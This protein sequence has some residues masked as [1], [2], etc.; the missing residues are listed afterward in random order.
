MDKIPSYFHQNSGNPLSRV[1]QYSDEL[2]ECCPYCNRIGLTDLELEY[3][4]NVFLPAHPL[5][6]E[7]TPHIAQ[8]PE[9]EIIL[10]LSE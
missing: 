3:R 8:F 10:E 9:K 4:S 7:S 1:F 2:T 6:C 5:P